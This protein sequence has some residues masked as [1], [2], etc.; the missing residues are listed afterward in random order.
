M[1]WQDIQSLGMSLQT[2]TEGL[3]MSLD[4]SYFVLGMSLEPN[5]M[6]SRESL[7]QKVIMTKQA[8]GE[9]FQLTS[10]YT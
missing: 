8:G 6:F 7:F 10:P 3:G 2:I 5:N 4:I 9:L 1:L